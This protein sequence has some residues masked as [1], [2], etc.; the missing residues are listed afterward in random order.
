MA[1][2][3]GKVIIDIASSLVDRCFDYAIPDKLGSLAVGTRVLVPF[4]RQTKEGYL[5]EITDHTDCPPNKLK[6]IIAPLEDFAVITPDQLKLADFLKRSYNIGLA[7]SIRLFLP[8]E[9]R[10]GKVKDLVKREAYLPDETKADQYAS[11]LRANATAAR[12]IISYLKQYGAENTAVL[13]NKFN[14]AALNKLVDCGVVAIRQVPVLRKPLGGLNATCPPVTLTETQGKVVERISSNPGN[15]L[16]HGVTGSGKTEVYMALMQRVLDQGKTGIMLVP[17]ISLTPQVLGNFRARFGDKVALMHSGLSTGERFDEWKRALMGKAQI[18]VGARSAIFSPLDN[19]GIIIIDEEHDGSYTSDS[20]PRYHTI[21]VAEERAKICGCSLVLGSATP[22]LE[23]YHKAVTGQYQ[24]LEMR[25]RIN[26]KPMPPLTIVDSTQEVRMGNNGIFSRALQD[27][28]ADTIASGNQ[29][30]IFINRRGYSSFLMCKECGFVAKCQN[31]DTALVYHK[32]E[33]ALKCHFCASKYKVFTQC[34]ECGSTNLKLGS[35]G[36]QQVVEELHK[37]FPNVKVLRMDNDTTTGKDAHHKILSAF[38]AGEAQI[39]V[40]TQMIAKGH[41]FP[42]VT[43]V[44]IVD[45]DQSLYQSSYTATERTFQLIT[46]VAGRAG[47]ADKQGT[48]ILQTYVPRHYVY[49]LASSYDYLSFY[50][51]EAN[52]RQVTNFP[53]F[54]KIVRVLFTSSAEEVAKSATKVYYDGVKELA[55]GDYNG[56]FI[57]IGAAKS[58]VGRIQ[59]KFRYQVML[60]IKLGKFNQ[61]ITQLYSLADKV[62]QNGDLS[63]YVEINPQNL[64]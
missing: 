54:A 30:M 59:N 60:R 21:E 52:L 40:G 55:K 4:G 56:E 35:T 29:A 41:D 9:M 37:L 13:N 5:I 38:R 26:R 53:P 19:L 36:S 50:K 43:L 45:A 34:P 17:E 46:Q 25:E 64:S 1:Q 62:K 14:S 44:G 57:Y 18:V 32:S 15:Y 23:S 22:C 63:I 24:L 33:N 42:A 11:S 12:G 3:Y 61:L 51:K 28:L 6:S 7:D 27:A 58:P 16:L 10:S 31:C 49:R 2:K 8:S 47:R 20:H 39:L 48:I